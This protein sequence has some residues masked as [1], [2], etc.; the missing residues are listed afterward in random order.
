MNTFRIPMNLAV[1]TFL[2][3]TNFISPFTICLLISIVNVLSVFAS[4]YLLRNR[5]KDVNI[6][7]LKNG[8][9]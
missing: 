1:I 7:K 8:T 6:G 2:L 3:L 5:P 4:V 9:L